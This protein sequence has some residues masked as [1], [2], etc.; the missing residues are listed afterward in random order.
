M[1]EPGEMEENIMKAVDILYLGLGA[2]FLA[3]DKVESLLEEMEK[4]GEI[5]RKDAE[6]FIKEAKTRAKKEQDAMDARIRGQIKKGLEEMGLAT[7]ADIEEL[8]KL[9][10]KG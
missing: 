10:M 3:K 4:R 6:S 5:S 8:K 9:I 7:K 1:N 2:A